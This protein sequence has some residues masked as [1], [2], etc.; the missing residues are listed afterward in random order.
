MYKRQF[1]ARVNVGFLQIQ[2]P[3]HGKFAVWER[4]AG[5]TLACGTGNCAAAATAIKNEAMESPVA[6]ENLGGTLTLEWEGEGMNIYLRGP[7]EM[8]FD[9]EIEI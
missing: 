6:L 1:P 5:Q 3:H 8:V 4:G 7:A 9:S 2:D